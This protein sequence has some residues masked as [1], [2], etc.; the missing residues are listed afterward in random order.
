VIDATSRGTPR[1]VRTEIVPENKDI[2]PATLAA[3]S[4]DEPRLVATGP[5]LSRYVDR[6]EDENEF[7]RGQIGVK[8]G[9]IKR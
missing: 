9:Q 8:D 1:Q 4:T 7:L 2:P 5:D 6:L 3:T